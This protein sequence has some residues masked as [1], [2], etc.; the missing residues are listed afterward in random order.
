MPF[1]RHR[2]TTLLILPH[3]DSI[4]ILPRRGYYYHCFFTESQAVLVSDSKPE[5]NVLTKPEVVLGA[6][7]KPNIREAKD[8]ADTC[9]H[10]AK[11]SWLDTEF[12]CLGEAC[13]RL[14]DCWRRSFVG[15]EE[16]GRG[17]KRMI[18]ALKNRMR[19]SHSTRN[20][21]HVILSRSVFPHCTHLKSR[22]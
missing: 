3:L 9:P 10:P 7:I 21:T 14:T 17:R 1:A 19:F 15:W 11:I 16:V 13:L 6:Y 20:Q 5:T 4:K 22:K 8:G 18:L 2:Y 12:E